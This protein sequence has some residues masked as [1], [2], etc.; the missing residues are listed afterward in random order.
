M[1]RTLLG[2]LRELQGAA[3]RSPAPPSALSRIWPKLHLAF[4][5]LFI[6]VAVVGRLALSARLAD[7]GLVFPVVFGFAGVVLVFGVVEEVLERM[8]LIDKKPPAPPLVDVSELPVRPAP[9]PIPEEAPR[10]R[11]VRPPGGALPAQ[12]GAASWG[13]EGGYV[14]RPD[15]RDAG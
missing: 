11:T 12:F 13:F 9:P 7:K 2:S 5:G 1:S 6:A 14:W 8:K 3:V 4:M 10:A 15:E